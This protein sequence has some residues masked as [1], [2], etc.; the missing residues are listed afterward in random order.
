MASPPLANLASLDLSRT[1][2]SKQEMQKVLRQRGRF[3]IVDGVLYL[4][5]SK[6]DVIVG[7]I[8]V[9]KD[10]WWAEDHIPGRPIFPG[11][12]MVEASAQLGSYDFF[13]RRPERASEFVG[14][15]GIGATRFREIVEPDC[16]LILVGKPG[17]VRDKLFTYDF[18]G[19]VDDRR[20]FETQITGTVL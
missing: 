2:V 5:P 6:D 20:A 17:R 4:D 8:D 16:R 10:D 3:A 1:I 7:Y 18:Q 14:F 12:L 9:R 13:H 15:M 19:Y 11:M